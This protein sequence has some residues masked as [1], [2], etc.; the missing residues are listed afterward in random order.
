VRPPLFDPLGAIASF[1]SRGHRVD[2]EQP[3]GAPGRASDGAGASSLAR[4]AP[5]S[6]DDRWW[7]PPVEPP[8]SPEPPSTEPP[9]PA[10][11]AGSPDE[12]I[13]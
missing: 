13:L 5:Q 12:P 9:P 7:A 10:G 2:D 3:D 11:A 4:G 6:Y 1:A 8:A